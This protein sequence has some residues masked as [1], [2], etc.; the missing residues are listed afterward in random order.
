MQDGRQGRDTQQEWAVGYK[1]LVPAGLF[2]S[3]GPDRMTYAA[4]NFRFRTA[5]KEVR[6]VSVSEIPEVWNKQKNSF[7]SRYYTF[8]P[9]TIGTPSR[10][11]LATAARSNCRDRK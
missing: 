2:Q 5:A 6:S 10:I 9:V 11:G 3:D 8:S 7:Q 1:Y 4:S